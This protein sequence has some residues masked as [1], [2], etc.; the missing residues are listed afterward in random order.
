MQGADG[1][2]S[3]FVNN[4]HT[5]FAKPGKKIKSPRLLEGYLR[6]PVSFL[7]QFS[8]KI[9][10]M[11]SICLDCDQEYERDVSAV[12]PDK[13]DTIRKASVAETFMADRSKI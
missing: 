11:S 7:L 10:L 5:E 9:T 6:P 8:Y 4:I 13:N 2:C 3:A 12:A 1:S